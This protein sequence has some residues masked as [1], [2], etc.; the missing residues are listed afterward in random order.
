MLRAIAVRLLCKIWV[1]TDGTFANL[2]VRM[3]SYL[4]SVDLLNVD[5]QVILDALHLDFDALHTK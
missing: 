3:F 5:I 2:Q 1:A 4:A